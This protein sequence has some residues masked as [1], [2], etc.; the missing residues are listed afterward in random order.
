MRK[1]CLSAPWGVPRGGGPGVGY[2]VQERDVPVLVSV[3][4]AAKSFVFPR[5]S[6]LIF[7]RPHKLFRGLVSQLIRF[8]AAPNRAPGMLSLVRPCGAAGM[9]RKGVIRFT[10]T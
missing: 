9:L 6:N 4:V 7:S 8:P 3:V 2:G 1:N 10:V 5:W